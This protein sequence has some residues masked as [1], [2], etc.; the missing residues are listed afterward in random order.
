METMKKFISA[1]SLTLLMSTALAQ[2]TSQLND[3]KDTADGKKKDPPIIIILC[4]P[5]PACEEN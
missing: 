5:F 4:M 2:N 3:Y 1:L